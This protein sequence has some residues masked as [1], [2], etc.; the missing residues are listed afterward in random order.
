MELKLQNI[1]K[2]YGEKVVLKDINVQLESGIYG[3]LGPNGAG[4]STLI[5]LLTDNLKRPWIL[6]TLMTRLATLHRVP[7]IFQSVC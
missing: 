1:T 7:H 4:K 2:N 6:G 5:K 3:L